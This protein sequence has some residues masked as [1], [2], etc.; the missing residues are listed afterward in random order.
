MT[1]P[2][3]PCA[4]LAETGGF[5][6]YL[7]TL[8]REGVTTMIRTQYRKPGTAKARYVRKAIGQDF[9]KWCEQSAEDSRYDIAQGTCDAEDLPPDIRKKC[10]ELEG[11]NA[12]F[13]ACEW[14]L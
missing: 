7:P 4:T 9:Y 1:P 10:D 2:T 3:Q 8:N 14:P 13:Y 11:K 5:G 6:P 12:G